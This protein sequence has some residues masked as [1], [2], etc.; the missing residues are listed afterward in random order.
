MD[1]DLILATIRQLTIDGALYQAMEFTGPTLARLG[2]SERLTICNMAVTRRT[3][4][5]D[6]RARQAMT[7]NG[8][9]GMTS[10][11]K[12]HDDPRIAGTVRLG[13]NVIYDRSSRL[14]AASPFPGAAPGKGDALPHLPE[15]RRWPRRSSADGT[16]SEWNGF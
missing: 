6:S 13:V 2:M 16:R 1:K 14:R 5:E 15:T 8:R 10:T 3:P 9:L 12:S 11:V 7:E 4:G